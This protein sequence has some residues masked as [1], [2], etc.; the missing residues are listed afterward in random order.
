MITGEVTPGREAVVAL[1][2]VGPSGVSRSIR[3]VIDTGFTDYLTLPLELVHAL[4]LEFNSTVTLI[5]ADERRVEFD[6]YLGSVDWDGE[7]REIPILAA[8]GVPLL[9]MSSFR[10]DR[11]TIDN[12]DGG[13]VIISKLQ[14]K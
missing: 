6:E 1:T 3:A 14:H 9:G 11:L 4:E 12:L 5:L 13:P 8:E 10:G 7:L 2:A